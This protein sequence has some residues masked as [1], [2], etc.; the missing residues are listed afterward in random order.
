MLPGLHQSMIERQRPDPCH[1]QSKRHRAQAIAAHVSFTMF[2]DQLLLLVTGV[3]KASDGLTS[4]SFPSDL[5]RRPMFDLL[6]QSEVGRHCI[7][8]RSNP[9]L[10]CPCFNGP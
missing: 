1:P 3:G 4:G 10:P 9:V 2:P 8:S 7:W 5:C 6:S